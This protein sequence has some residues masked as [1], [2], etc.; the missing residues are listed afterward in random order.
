MCQ[1]R[2]VTQQCCHSTGVL[3]CTQGTTAQIAVFRTHTKLTGAASHLSRETRPHGIT[4]TTMCALLAVPGGIRNRDPRAQPQTY[5]DPCCAEQRWLQSPVTTLISYQHLAIRPCEASP[6]GCS[7]RL[8]LV[9][10]RQGKDAQALALLHTSERL[11]LLGLVRGDHEAHVIKPLDA[12]NIAVDH[13]NRH[14]HDSGR[15]RGR[16]QPGYSS[17]DRSASCRRVWLLTTHCH[18]PG[19]V[20][21]HCVWRLLPSL[22]YSKHHLAWSWQWHLFTAETKAY[23]AVV[24]AWEVEDLTL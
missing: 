20:E 3:Q 19:R 12:L 11:R 6:S 4:A 7:C 9:L 10:V 14:T 1:G 17:Y 5:R 16:C 8:L 23:V 24:V 15:S 22:A 13:L 18:T 2:P 21:H